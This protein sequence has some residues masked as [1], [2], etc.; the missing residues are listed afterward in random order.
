M[1]TDVKTVRLV[2]K[3]QQK[4]SEAKRLLLRHVRNLRC[5]VEKGDVVSYA[6]VTVMSDGST[7]TQYGGEQITPLLGGIE[8]LRKR[9]LEDPDDE[10]DDS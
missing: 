2:P 3:Q 10:P 1:S 5:H 6:V 7:G 4:A 8:W 9:I